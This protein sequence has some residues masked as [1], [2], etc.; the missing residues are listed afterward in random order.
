MKQRCLQSLFPSPSQALAMSLLDTHLITC[1]MGNILLSLWI[2]CLDYWETTPVTH[3]VCRK[4]VKKDDR[5]IQD[6]KQSPTMIKKQWVWSSS[7]EI[8]YWFGTWVSEVDLVNHTLTG[9]R[10][11][12][13]K[14]Q[15]FDNP[16]YVI[17]PEG[18]PNARNRNIHR[19]LL[20]LVNDLPVKGPT[21]SADT[22]L[23]PLG[24]LKNP[25]QRTSSA[26]NNV[27]SDTDDEDEWTRGY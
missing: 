27:I 4:M 13:V 23:T 19:N 22:A 6:R 5:S 2:S 14:E 12:V 25:H 3:G 11:S 18:D 20:L 7:Q 21:Q 8:K 24:K 16:V 17:H 1:C 9:R 10:K 15:I 26:D